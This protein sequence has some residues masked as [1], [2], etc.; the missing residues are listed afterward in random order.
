[1]SE[2]IVTRPGGQV[3][4]TIEIHQDGDQICAIIGQMPEEQAIGFGDSISHALA[5]L[6]IDM[7]GKDWEY[8]L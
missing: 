1:M 2:N 5:A 4:I 7:E 8:L 6:Q 3:M